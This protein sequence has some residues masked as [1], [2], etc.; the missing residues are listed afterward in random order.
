MWRELA[1]IKG[2]EVEYAVGTSLGAEICENKSG[3]SPSVID[4]SVTTLFPLVM[5]R[6]LGRDMN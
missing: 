6:C 1:A 2:E 3:A 5:K 4:A